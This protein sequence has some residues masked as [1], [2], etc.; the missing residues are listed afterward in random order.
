MLTPMERYGLTALSREELV[1][2]SLEIDECLGRNEDD[3]EL[4]PELAALID[5]RLDVID[6]DP[7]PGIPWEEALERIRNRQR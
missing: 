5:E 4:T 2:L 3:I 7:Q 1:E 6:A